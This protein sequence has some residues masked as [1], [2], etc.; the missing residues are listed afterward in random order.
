MRGV[1]SFKDGIGPALAFLRTKA[2]LS[3]S[4]L[5][6][7]VGRKIQPRLSQVE[8]GEVVPSGQLIDEYLSQCGSDVADLA[9]AYLGPD[10]SE[11]EL[12]LRAL[13]AMRLGEIPPRLE[14]VALQQLQ[15]QRRTLLEA[16]GKSPDEES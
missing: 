2:G 14:R 7:L 13:R 9:D 12:A 3:Q 16:L 1:G 8:H 6:K 15:A 10:P 4:A 11:E 5:A